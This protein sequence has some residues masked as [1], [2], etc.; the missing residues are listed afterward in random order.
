MQRIENCVCSVCCAETK[1]IVVLVEKPALADGAHSQDS[2]VF[3]ANLLKGWVFGGL[4]TSTHAYSCHRVC[5]V[6][7]TKTVEDYLD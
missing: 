3:V 6:C 2:S 5:E 7:G 1:H 4:M